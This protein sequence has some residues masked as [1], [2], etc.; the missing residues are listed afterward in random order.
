M[1]Y[2]HINLLSNSIKF[3]LKK[4]QKVNYAC[5]RSFQ[6]TN[7]HKF[8]MILSINPR[9]QF[10]FL[11]RPIEH[12]QNFQFLLFFVLHELTSSNYLKITT[13][14]YSNIIKWAFFY[15][16]CEYK[17]KSII[18][19]STNLLQLSIIPLSKTVW[20]K[21]C[22]FSLKLNFQASE[23]NNKLFKNLNFALL[24]TL[25]KFDFFCNAFFLKKM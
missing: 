4:E 18:L 23:N 19:H 20:A 14:K 3:S 15:V 7:I 22:F 1:F 9:K 11:N 10:P 2:K 16:V 17:L 24:K 5:I 13:A 6:M 25:W 21:F 8:S 12:E